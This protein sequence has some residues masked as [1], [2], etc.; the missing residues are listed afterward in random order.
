A[1]VVIS[2]EEAALAAALQRLEAQ[3]IRTRRLR[4]SH[5]F[6]S[7]LMDP[8]LEPFA[9]AASGVAFS[10]PGLR[11]VANVSGRL[12]TAQEIATADYWVRHLRQPVQFAKGIATLQQQGVS[13]FVEIGPGTALLGMGQQCLPQDETAWVSSLRNGRDDWA[14]MLD[15][16]ASLYVQGV[17]VDW[18]GLDRPF[19]YRP[20]ALPTYPFQRQRHWIAVPR[21]RSAAGARAKP[22]VHPLLGERL[23]SALPEAQ[24]ENELGAESFGFIADHHVQGVPILPAAAFIELGLAAAGEHFRARAGS[25]AVEDLV[26][27]ETLSFGDG[28]VRAVQ[29]I[30]SPEATFRVLSQGQD[31]EEWRLHAT[32]RLATATAAET[33]GEPIQPIR[34]RCLEHWSADEHHA[35]MRQHGLDF[36]PAMQGVAE[37]HRRDGEALGWIRAP[38]AVQAE[39]SGFRLHPALLDACLQVVGAALPTERPADPY[40]PLGID[41]FRWFAHPTGELW[42]HVTLHLPDG[43]LPDTLRANV[44]LLDDVGNLLAEAGGLALRRLSRSD[45][46]AESFADWLYEV[47]WRALT[48]RPPLPLAGGG[49]GPRSGRA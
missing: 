25:L 9:A 34:A 4:V 22:S 38:E 23:R 14:Q 24:Y 36:G 8:V 46:S 44:R 43:P 29:T 30:V 40:L 1:N 41:A 33:T 35:R 16:L 39:L 21:L 10:P 45:A 31:E 28:A 12:A 19:G 5:A 49:R 15:G 18:E 48:P 13:V 11:L 27:R 20:V 32:G 26:I 37:I 3:G 47:E 42:S 7:P 17:P 6:H 2:G